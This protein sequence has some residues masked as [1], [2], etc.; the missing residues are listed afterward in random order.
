LGSEP[1]DRFT[2][3]FMS[4]SPLT[5]LAQW[6][7]ALVVLLILTPSFLKS[8]NTLSLSLSEVELTPELLSEITPKLS[9]PTSAAQLDI[10]DRL[11]FGKGNIVRVEGKSRRYL[12]LA[13]DSAGKQFI[14]LFD[15]SSYDLNDTELKGLIHFNG[16]LSKAEPTPQGSVEVSVTYSRLSSGPGHAYSAQAETFV[17]RHWE[18][19]Q[20]NQEILGQG[21][22]SVPTSTNTSAQTPIPA[23]TGGKGNAPTHNQT[24]ESGPVKTSAG[25]AEKDD[26]EDE[27]EDSTEPVKN[28]PIL[29]RRDRSETAKPTPPSTSSDVKPAGR[30]GINVKDEQDVVVYRK[31]TDAGSSPLGLGAQTQRT[32]QPSREQDG[33]ALIPEGYVTLGSDAIVDKEKPLHRVFVQA[34]Y[35]DKREVTNREFKD[36]CDATGHHIPHY[37]KGQDL[38]KDFAKHPVVHVNWLDAVAYAK[39]AGKRLPTEAEW[40]RAAKGPNSYRY[41]YGNAYDPQKANTESKRTTPV[42]SYALSEFGLYDMTGNV[43]EWTSTLFKPYPYKGDDGRED[44]QSSGPRVLRGGGHSSGEANARCLVRV[45]GLADEGTPSVGFR[46]ARDAN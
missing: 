18:S 15:L 24:Q 34:F 13:L 12:L 20:Q 23:A 41:T 22:K 17:R 39:W 40:E 25:S 33:M 14:K 10:L 31:K 30:S 4:L 37:W 7:S 1:S 32:P 21:D 26:K 9:N 6:L 29:L 11:V 45:D 38:P 46:C 42:G 27:A 5:R 16:V 28:K 44:P 3:R 43:A 36:F 19:K 8:E 2:H 35:I